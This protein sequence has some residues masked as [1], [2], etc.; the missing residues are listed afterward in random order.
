[1]NKEEFNNLIDETFERFIDK[2]CNSNNHYAVIYDKNGLNY[3]L[4]LV[5]NKDIEFVNELYYFTMEINTIG[6]VISI[7]ELL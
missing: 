3:A 6:N 4:F 2:C 7:D 1:M 5:K